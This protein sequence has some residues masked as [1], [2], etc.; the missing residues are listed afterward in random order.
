MTAVGV[1]SWALPRFA[2]GTLSSCPSLPH[3]ADLGEKA[4]ALKQKLLHC[5]KERFA[6]SKSHQFFSP[7]P[8]P[9]TSFEYMTR[10]LDQTPRLSFRDCHGDP[11]V[12]AALRSWL[13]SPALGF[14]FPFF[15]NTSHL[16][17]GSPERKLL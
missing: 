10:K 9:P 13:F 14:P 8:A 17:L 15:G 3:P 5:F 11:A 1:H 6:L 7:P 4:P 12:G 16:R 2:A